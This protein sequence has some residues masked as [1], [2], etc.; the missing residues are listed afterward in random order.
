MTSR[1]R[2]LAVAK[3][4]FAAKGYEGTS[5]RKIAK[6][7]GLSVA[8]MFHYFSSK[9][10]I[11]NEIIIEFVDSGYDGLNAIRKND[12]PPIEKVEDI[13]KFCVRHLAGNKNELSILVSESKSLTPEHYKIFLKK[14]NIYI[15]ALKGLFQELERDSRLKSVKPSVLTLLFFGMVN[16]TYSWYNKKGEIGLNDLE[17]IITEIFL[18]GILKENQETDNR[19]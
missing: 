15:E 7:S 13:C 17:T 18:R 19:H 8:G 12:K 11:L 5:I 3:R 9:E 1:E 6:E 2:I 4:L 16:W 14:Q 10:E